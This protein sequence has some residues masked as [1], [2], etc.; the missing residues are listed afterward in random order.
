MRCHIMLFEECYKIYK[1]IIYDINDGS[2]IKEHLRSNAFKN[3]TSFWLFH[4]HSQT[5]R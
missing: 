4:M 3:G 2:Y 1:F 5:F